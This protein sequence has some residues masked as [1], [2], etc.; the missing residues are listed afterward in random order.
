MRKLLEF[1]AQL[2]LTAIFAGF[3]GA[4]LGGFAGLVMVAAGLAYSGDIYWFMI[5]GAVLVAVST[6]A[7]ARRNPDDDPDLDV[8]FDADGPAPD[9]PREP[10]RPRLRLV[11]SLPRDER[12]NPPNQ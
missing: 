7:L 4:L 8:D 3:I 11:D 1:V 2:G 12:D 9:L 5:G 6:I 10:E